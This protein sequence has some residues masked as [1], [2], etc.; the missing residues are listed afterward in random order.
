MTLELSFILLTV[1]LAA[2]VLALALSLLRLSL[3][4]GGTNRENPPTAPDSSENVKGAEPLSLRRA[5]L[6]EHERAP[7]L[8]KELA[9][10]FEKD[11]NLEFAEFSLGDIDA[12]EI[13]SHRG[14]K[15]HRRR[16]E[17]AGGMTGSFEW[18]E[19]PGAKLSEERIDEVA[20]ITRAYMANLNKMQEYK[21]QAIR[22]P[23]TG[24]FNAAY[25]RTRLD[26]EI[27]RAKRSKSSLGLMIIDVDNFKQIN[28]THGHPV[29][30][31]ILNR[32]AQLL[33][34]NVRST[35]I[36]ARYGGDELCVILPD[37]DSEQ[38]QNFMLRL[39]RRVRELAEGLDREDRATISIGA[40]VA[41]LQA[42]DG[43]SLF[44]AADDALLEAKRSGR[45]RAVMYTHQSETVS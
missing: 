34:E 43:E 14:A 9:V 37:S 40:A 4:K 12:K 13:N 3:S 19:R 1:L 39:H 25:F 7:D 18:T 44:K 8:L 24:L 31:N 38:T 21:R 36:V 15:T 32:L 45:N 26:E 35:D 17:F 10:Q 30:D 27:K 20:Q 33:N 5:R 11:F 16:I 23:L 2:L 28:D 22:D 42:A 6:L 29:G 41:P